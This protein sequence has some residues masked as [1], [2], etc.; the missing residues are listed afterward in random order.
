MSV[1]PRLQL[2]TAQTLQLS[3]QLKQAIELLTLSN[4]EVENAI[5][6]AVERNPLLEWDRGEGSAAP[7]PP[8]EGEPLFDPASAAD[9]FDAEGPAEGPTGAEGEGFDFERLAG[10]EPSL[11][12]HLDQQ[13]ASFAPDDRA[14]AAAIILRLED[15]GYL[16]TSLDEIA[17]A[18]GSEARDV[19]RVL[20]LVQRFDP[21]GIAARS[22]AECLAIQAREADR[23]DPAMA[24]LLENLPLLARGE[25]AALRRICEVDDEDL[26]DMIAELRG[27]DPKPGC[28]FRHDP[29]TARTIVPDLLVVRRGKS[30]AVELNPDTLP[31]LAIDRAAFAEYKSSGGR[32]AGTF[33]TGAM[34]EAKFLV[35]ALEQRARTILRVGTAI[36][37][38]QAGFFERGAVGLR[39]MTMA[40]LADGLGLHETT[41]SRVAASKYLQCDRGTFALRYFFP[42]GVANEDGR[43]ASAEGVKARIRAL[44]AGEGAK[45]LSDDALAAALLAE[46]TSVARRTVAKYRESLGLGSSSE[47]KRRKVIAAP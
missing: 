33:V 11:G 37:H 14:V 41:I 4:L 38:Q 7:A 47:R 5:A 25:R 18:S 10:G 17:A 44:I 32:A 12:E 6:D 8:A 27:Y 26:G 42:S 21:C 46:G 1:A 19:E 39:P 22:L 20:G 23:Y 28:R 35:R 2:R 45:P 16:E 40:A 3:P 43:G 24:R 31:R 15:S 34:G 13:A 36:L 30:W 9:I 29:A